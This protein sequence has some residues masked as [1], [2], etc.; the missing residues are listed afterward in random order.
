MLQNNKKLKTLIVGLWDTFW[1]NGLSNPITAIEQ[2]S[3]LLFIKKLDE[4]ET[5]NKTNPQYNSLFSGEYTPYSEQTELN[6]LTEE[7]KIKLG[8]D[9]K[10]MA[11]PRP[12]SELRWSSFTKISS[13]EKMFEHV[14]NNVFPYVKNL[15]SGSTPYT[16]SMANAIF[17]IP[18]ASLLKQAIDKIEEIY[19]EIERDAKLGGYAFQDIQGDVYEMLLGELSQAG[20][21]GQFRIMSSTFLSSKCHLKTAA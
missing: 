6:A 14:K 3:Y 10:S 15:H 7:E 9:L 20:K 8:N 2:L 11:K 17:A 12:A 13:P 19:V 5:L 18:K 1:G 16:E 21:N 4:L